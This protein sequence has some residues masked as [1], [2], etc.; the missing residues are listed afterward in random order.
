MPDRVNE[1][2]T[3]EFPRG[4]YWLGPA[5]DPF[6]MDCRAASVDISTTAPVHSAVDALGVVLAGVEPLLRALAEGELVAD[7]VE[8][9]AGYTGAPAGLSQYPR[10]VLGQILEFMDSIDEVTSLPES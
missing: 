8:R 6:R 2:S 1:E 3:H 7:V 4:G 5:L 9:V 10:S